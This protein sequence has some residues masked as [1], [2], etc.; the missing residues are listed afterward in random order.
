VIAWRAVVAG[1][2]VALLIGSSWFL[3]MAGRRGG[4]FLGVNSYEFL[5]RYYDSSFPGPLRGP[6]FF[7]AILPGEIA[8]WPIVVLSAIAF[9]LR[10]WKTLDRRS[11]DGL[12]VAAAWFVGVMVLCSFSHYK[13]PHYALPA[14]PPL[15]LLAGAALDRARRTDAMRWL[16]IVGV[17]ITAAVVLAAGAA[18]TL[19]AFRLP[20]SLRSGALIIGIACMIGGTATLAGLWRQSGVAAVSLASAIG[21]AYGICAALLLP[22][23]SAQAYPYP[24]LGRLVAERTA[25]TVALASIGAH[26]A[27]VYYADRP[28]TFLSTPS[29]AARFLSSSDPRLLVLS[30]TEYEAMNQSTTV[31][32][33]LASRRRQNPRLS[34]LLDGRFLS[35]GTEE[36]LVGNAAGT[37]AYAGGN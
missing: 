29:E 6:L 19:A 36:L 32:R 24:A 1:V 31:G 23:L 22:Q 7:V 5:Q 27:L 3:Y 11:Q 10:S 13:L 15:M 8:P 28:V 12:V 4:A 30:R 35:G 2:A 26:T 20:G 16:V 14:Y 17:A 9:L 18:A 34:R 25:P 21:I 37:V 33:E